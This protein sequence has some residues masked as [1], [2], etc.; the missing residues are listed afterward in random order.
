MLYDDS[1]IHTAVKPKY[2]TVVGSDI[3]ARVYQVSQP[4]N[5]TAWVTL[6]AVIRRQVGDDQWNTVRRET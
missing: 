1:K 6:F 2:S 3:A 5:L 4:D